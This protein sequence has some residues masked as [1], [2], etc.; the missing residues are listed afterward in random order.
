MNQKTYSV[1]PVPMDPASIMKR[2]LLCSD[3]S[4]EQKKLGVTFKK[5]LER[6]GNERD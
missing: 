1:D 6:D 3:I 5:Q 2:L 4:A